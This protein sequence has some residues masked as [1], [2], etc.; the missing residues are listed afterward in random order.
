M[1]AGKNDRGLETIPFQIVNQSGLDDAPLYIW[2]QGIIPDS[3]PAE[4][5]YVNDLKGSLAGVPKSSEKIT[6]SMLLPGKDTTLVLPRLVSLRI[7]LSFGKQLFTTSPEGIPVSPS[8]WSP[9][10]PVQG[11]NYN[12]L[13]DFFE[14]T[15]TRDGAATSLGANLTQLDFFGL[16]LQL[17]NYG[18]KPDLTTPEQLKSGFEGNARSAILK[19]IKGLPEPWRKLVL[20]DAKSAF[21]GI[22]LRIFCPYHGMELDLFPKDQL[23]AYIDH[24]WSYYASKPLAVTIS[25]GEYTG[26]VQ[27]SGQ[28]SGLFVFEKPSGSKPVMIRNPNTNSRPG[29]VSGS[30]DVYEC[31][32]Q[33]DIV[34]E[35]STDAIDIARDLGAGFLRSTLGQGVVNG[36]DLDRLPLCDQTARYYLHDPINRYAAILHEHAIAQKAYAFGYDDVCEQS[37]VGITKNP[38][39]LVL[40]VHP[41][42][43]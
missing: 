24:V 29:F 27:S 38:T 39:R 7:Y 30:K 6:L 42:A 40:T 41:V 14:L 25:G 13:W 5:V 36:V 2:I 26:R 23:A 12:G 16:A 34:G 22:P 33:L 8:G 35:A 11:E 3:N 10:D 9:G 31:Q 43:G 21:P 19:E 4:Y 15:W 18:Y 20:S 17:D 1:D 37:S 28:N 32:V